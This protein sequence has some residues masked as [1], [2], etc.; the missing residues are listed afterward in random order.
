MSIVDSTADDAYAIFF[1]CNMTDPIRS[2]NRNM[3][4][5]TPF[6]DPTFHYIS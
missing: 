1:L 3:T 5:A 6:G 4:G 2:E